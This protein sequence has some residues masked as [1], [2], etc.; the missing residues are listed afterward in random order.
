MAAAARK[1]GTGIKGRLQRRKQRLLQPELAGSYRCRKG[2]LTV[3]ARVIRSV[4]ETHV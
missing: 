4:T 3:S 1:Q 2:Q